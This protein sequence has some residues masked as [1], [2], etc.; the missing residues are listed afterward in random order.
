MAM[1]SRKSSRSTSPGCAA[2]CAAAPPP[3]S[4]HAGFQ[5]FRLERLAQIIVR[6]QIQ[7]AHA[8]VQCIAR[9]QHQDGRA[10]AAPAQ[11]GQHR[12]AVDIGKANVQYR[13]RIGFAAD[14]GQGILA[15]RDMIDGMPPC[16]EQCRNAARQRGVVL[17]DQNAD[18]APVA[19]R[20]MTGSF[21]MPP[22][23]LIRT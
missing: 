18:G 23:H 4:A 3:Q 5:F 19:E 1:G 7:P 16:T 12:E 14:H 8:V 10:R 13:Q 11:F 17:D 21:C 20:L 2:R 22:S 6:A 15:G 9:R